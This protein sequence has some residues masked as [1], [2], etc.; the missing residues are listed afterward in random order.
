MAKFLAPKKAS[1]PMAVL[2][3]FSLKLCCWGPLVLTGIAGISGSTAYFS[4]LTVF[5][6][7]L[8]AVA[9]LS[10]AVA[11]YQAYKPIPKEKCEN[12][13]H[14][15]KGFIKSKLYVWLVA[16]FILLMSLLS[17]YPTLFYSHTNPQMVL[18][19]A[20]NFKSVKLHIKG[21]TCAGCE[22]SINHSVKK[23]GGILRVE[24]SHTEGT[25]TIEYDKNKVTV[26][27]IKKVIEDKGYSVKTKIK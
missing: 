14:E 22:E 9:L 15:K 3:A 25:S 2:S 4:W 27:E 5:R 23:I 13:S 17:Y 12:C 1:I 20:S 7:Y 19:D 18:A 24:T 6:P 26:S 8:L 16:S 21:M 10:L 11:F